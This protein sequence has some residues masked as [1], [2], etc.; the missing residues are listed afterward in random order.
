MLSL[1]PNSPPFYLSDN[2]SYTSFRSELALLH[3]YLFST[4]YPTVVTYAGGL[5]YAALCRTYPMSD[6]S[7]IA[8]CQTYPMLPYI[9]PTLRRT[10][11]TLDLPY[12]NLHWTYPM[13]PYVGPTLHQTYPTSDLPYTNLHWTYPTLPYVRPTLQCPTPD[14]S[15]AGDLP[16]A[17]LHL[18]NSKFLVCLQVISGCNPL[19]TFAEPS[20]A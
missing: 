14:L 1:Y 2:P 9:R 3:I 15:Y 11:P 4:T 8:L 13:S 16:Y 18:L 20:G 10:Y 12:T 19:C 6:L 17:N 5:P 7:Y